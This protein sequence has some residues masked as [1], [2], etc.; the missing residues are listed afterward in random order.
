MIPVELILILI[1]PV[2]FLFIAFEW[3][4]SE[5]RQTG[6]YQWRDSLANVVLAAM[7]QFGDALS[8]LL[9]LPIL[10]WLSQFALWQLPFSL[11]N[12]LWLFLLQDFLYYWFHRA[13]HQCRWL[14]A[15]HVVHHSS[16]LMNFSTAFRQSLT[17]PL[18]G[19]WL[20]WTPLV[21]VGFAVELV[22]AVVAINLAFQ[23]FVHTRWGQHWGWLGL[24]VNTPSW[25]RVH[26]A[27]NP[28]YIDKNY[29]GV[30]VIWDRLFGTFE[31]EH[32]DI[33]CEYGI[34]EDFSSV[35]PLTITFYEWRRIWHD[36]RHSDR[37]W[38]QLLF[39]APKAAAA[40]DLRPQ[41]QSQTAG[42]GQGQD[43]HHD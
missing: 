9:L 13:S 12:L 4:Q 14:W 38:W 28:Q 19:M 21:L 36:L 32:A 2:F 37:P 31:A 24:I 1:S 11:S 10:N 7:H 25:H 40:N 39:G 5:R 26:H 33:R 35:N 23:F 43:A 22:L 29:A 34:T 6:W 17:Y 16:T 3:Y 27:R 30:L 42:V 15:S 8:L 41:R 18:S 20:F